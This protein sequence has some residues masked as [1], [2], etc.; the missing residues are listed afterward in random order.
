MQQRPTRGVRNLYN[1]KGPFGQANLRTAAT[2][3]ALELT[4]TRMR[5]TRYLSDNND[6]L[7]TALALYERNTRLSEAF[8]TPLQSCEV[9][10]RNTISTCMANVYGLDWFS[11]GNA[12]L[13]NDARDM[14][15]SAERELQHLNPLPAGAIVAELKFAFWV[16]L[17]G[18]G[19]DATLWRRALYRGFQ[20]GTGRQRTT[21]H[22]RFNM[23]RRFRNRIAHHEPIYHRDLAQLHAEIIEAIGWTC[24]STQ[25]WTLHHSRVLAVLQ[26]P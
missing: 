5:L 20:R 11:N 21:V 1:R 22:G 3:L 25:A 4:I 9:T 8:Y 14:I 16:S 13:N 17:L 26:G 23:I 6:D 19:Y 12:P 2:N 15:L 7:D 18:P 24:A 10:L